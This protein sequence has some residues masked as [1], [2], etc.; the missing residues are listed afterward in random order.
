MKTRGA[1]DIGNTRVKAGIFDENGKLTQIE[2]FPELREAITWLQ[3][4][5]ITNVMIS[6]VKGAGVTPSDG[7]KIRFVESSMKL[8]FKNLY[9]SP[10]TLG[11]DR[12]AAMSA[13]AS[14]FPGR[15]S[16]VFDI[17]TCITI[18]LL[19]LQ[20]E[21]KGG[22]ISPG[23]QMRLKAMAHYTQKL[24]LATM[25][26][27]DFTMGHDTYSA[28]SNGVA[29]GILHEMEGYITKARELYPDVNILLCGG[30]A[31]Y[32]EKQLKYRIFADQNLVLLGL[33][34]LSLLND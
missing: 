17:G 3:T 31:H 12:I 28:L 22:N 7:M 6:D 9:M 1:I 32:F 21:Y 24:P 13:A 25:E 23:V 15:A 5:D 11:A 29:T 14:L 2:F 20:N 34:H 8:P 26:N 4:H 30:D 33:Y 16:L 10:E 19:N 18:D 27:A